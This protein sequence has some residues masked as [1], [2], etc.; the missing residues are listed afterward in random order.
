MSSIM[1]ICVKDRLS[2]DSRSFSVQL[3]EHLE[4]NALDDTA[5]NWELGTSK[6]CEIG[7]NIASSHAAFVNTPTK[8]LDSLELMTKGWDCNIPDNQR[9]ATATVTSSED[10]L[11]VGIVLAR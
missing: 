7:I 5:R 6:A 9:L 1:A 2:G 8:L 10:T 11:K 4:R 3:L